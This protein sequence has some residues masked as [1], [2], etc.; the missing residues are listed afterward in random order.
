MATNVDQLRA[1]LTEYQQSLQKH[2]KQL[3]GDFEEL[4]P[5][6]AGLRCEYESAAAEELLVAWSE[7]AR[8]FEEYMQNTRHLSQFLE[9]RITHLNS[10]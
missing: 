1:G 3:E 7:T 5:L 2:V 9:D 6:W 4:Q 10:L 8:W